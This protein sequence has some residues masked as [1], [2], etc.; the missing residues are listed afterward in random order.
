[1][2]RGVLVIAI[3]AAA[4]VD[5]S[6]A[7]CDPDDDTCSLSPIGNPCRTDQDCADGRCVDGTCQ[8]PPTGSQATACANVH[9]ASGQFCANGVCL[10]ATP[11]CKKL[12]RE[13]PSQ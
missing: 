10:P 8:V 4:C 7:G 11:N 9:C 2:G 1:M 13:K 6:K 5:K 12:R 3:L